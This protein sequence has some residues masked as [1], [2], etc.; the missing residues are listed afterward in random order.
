MPTQKIEI[1]SLACTCS[2]AAGSGKI[3]YVLY[4][5]AALDEWIADAARKYD[6]TIVVITGIDWN[7]DLTPWPAPGVP[8]GTPDFAGKAAQFLARLE[9]LVP[10][11]E[12][13]L[14][15]DPALTRRL[16][17]VSLSGL[18]ALWQWPQ[19]SLFDDIACLSGSFWYEGFVDWF[20]KQ[21]LSAKTGLAYF[22]LG[23]KEPH[24]PVAAFRKVGAATA[25]VV[26]QLKA[27]GVRAEF[28]WVPGDHYQFPIERLNKAMG[29]LAQ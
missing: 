16:V 6:S 29:A 25:A 19:T 1:E 7:N 14:A 24:S 4:P 13:Q 27:E 21:N 26:E 17:G 12:K 10:Q 11:V 28:E 22:L 2:V 5:F 9:K 8:A 15:V 23:K 18:F 20:A 3:T